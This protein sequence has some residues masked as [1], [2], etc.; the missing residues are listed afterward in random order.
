MAKTDLN[1]LDAL[2]TVSQKLDFLT[3]AF[4]GEFACILDDRAQAGLNMILFDLRE[5]VEDVIDR[6][7]QKAPGV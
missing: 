2:C 7:H 6:L 5:S 4:T 1:C 3:F